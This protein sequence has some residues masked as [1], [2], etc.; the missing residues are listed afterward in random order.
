VLF[1]GS[2]KFALESLK[3]ILGAKQLGVSALQV[4]CPPDN[5]PVKYKPPIPGI[6]LARC[7]I[8]V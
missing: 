2:D 7:C 1:F 3:A 8:I 4:V 6:S 5:Q